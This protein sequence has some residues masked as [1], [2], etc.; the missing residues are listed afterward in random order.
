MAA[1]RAASGTLS[2]GSHSVGTSYT[3]LDTRSAAGVYQLGVDLTNMANGDVV[4]IVIEDR[5]LAADGS[6]VEVYRA[7]FADVQVSP[8][9]HFP[10]HMGID[11]LVFKLRQ[12]AG[13][14]RDFKWVVKA[15]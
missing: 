1:T 13:T 12:V 4:D 3:T 14:A 10:A 11:Q 8:F 5:V 7:T 6:Q 2:S 15:A 9:V